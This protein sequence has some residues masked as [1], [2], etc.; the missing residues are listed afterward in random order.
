MIISFQNILVFAQNVYCLEQNQG[1]KGIQCVFVL[2][3]VWKMRNM[4][5]SKVILSCVLETSFLDVTTNLRSFWSKF[6]SRL[7]LFCV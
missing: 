1:T 7:I 5:F 3:I 6:R 2:E 4:L